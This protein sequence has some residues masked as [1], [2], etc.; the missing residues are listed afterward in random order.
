[1]RPWRSNEPLPLLPPYKAAGVLPIR[2]NSETGAW[3]ALLA[4]EECR[5]TKRCRFFTHPKGC[6]DGEACEFL[7]ITGP[8]TPNEKP[9]Y[10]LNFLGGKRDHGEWTSAVTAAREFHEETHK[11]VSYAEAQGFTSN[12]KP[13]RIYGSYDLYIREWTAATAF[14]NLVERYNAIPE[15]T[16]LACAQVLEWIPLK[17]LCDTVVDDPVVGFA[18]TVN[19]QQ[20]PISHLL[21]SFCVKRGNGALQSFLQWDT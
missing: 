14:D 10:K 6:W 20:R 8:E 18:I 1:M 21:W 13:L 12:I 9:M 5:A 11:L 2:Q 16:W 17:A 19:Q 15:R 3:E 4:F 7:H